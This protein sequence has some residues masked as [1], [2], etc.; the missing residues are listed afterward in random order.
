MG[1]FDDFDHIH[2][3]LLQL[4]RQSKKTILK[5]GRK[6]KISWNYADLR[7]EV[8]VIDTTGQK[9]HKACLR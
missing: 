8:D 9:I 7:V 2:S 1:L 6:S 4:Q 5:F 3:K